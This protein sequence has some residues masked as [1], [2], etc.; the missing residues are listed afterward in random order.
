MNPILNPQQSNPNMDNF[1]QQLN[2]LK[3]R[4][5]DP[6]QQIQRLL[7]SGR[8]S[9]QQYNVAVQQAQQIIRMMGGK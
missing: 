4:G 8:V 7:N 5:G 3:Q 6:N 2:Q 9:Q 1:M